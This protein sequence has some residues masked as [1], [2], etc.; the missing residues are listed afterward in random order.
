MLLFVWGSQLLPIKRINCHCQFLALHGSSVRMSLQQVEII[1]ERDEAQC[2]LAHATNTS[3]AWATLK[4]AIRP[5][6]VSGIPA[7]PLTIHCS[8]ETA[9]DLLRI[10]ALHC[11]SAV[12]KIE[13]ALTT[14]P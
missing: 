4:V 1:L 5:W 14:S 9:R 8:E 6:I 11:Q 7:P 12:Q 2:L 13:Q 10:A 3:I